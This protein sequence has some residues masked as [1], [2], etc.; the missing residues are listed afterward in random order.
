MHEDKGK[1]ESSI[2]R[3]NVGWE[4][5]PIVLSHENPANVV[6]RITAVE[7]A[8]HRSVSRELE[9]HPKCVVV[10]FPAIRHTP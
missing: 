8:V 9:V 10:I 7:Q 3:P 4:G 1:E 5:N 2:D 6:I